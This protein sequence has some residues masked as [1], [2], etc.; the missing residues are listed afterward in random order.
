MQSRVN[1]GGGA[2]N[3][4]FDIGK[5]LSCVCMYTIMLKCNRNDFIIRN[6]RF[7]QREL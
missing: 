7:K 1:Q 3:L 6:S 5:V 4:A 2:I